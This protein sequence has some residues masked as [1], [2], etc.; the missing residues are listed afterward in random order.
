MVF[1]LE[2]HGLLS[3]HFESSS[4]VSRLP[5]WPV[6]IP[7]PGS[8]VPPPLI[9]KRLIVPGDGGGGCAKPVSKIN[10]PMP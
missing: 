3:F 1:S 10:D 9:L 6:P 2:V 7:D 8:G 4:R 5:R